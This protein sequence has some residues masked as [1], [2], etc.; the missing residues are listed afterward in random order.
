MQFVVPDVGTIPIAN[1]WP[2]SQLISI[3]PFPETLS[4]MDV[5]VSTGPQKFASDTS[6]TN[7]PPPVL[8]VIEVPLPD[9]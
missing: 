2:V 8:P 1:A 3:P 7:T 6:Q 9:G 4:V 5:P